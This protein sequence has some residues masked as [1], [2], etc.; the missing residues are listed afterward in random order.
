MGYSG[1]TIVD[2][3]MAF[4]CALSAVRAMV[5]SLKKSLMVDGGGFNTDGPVNVALFFSELLASGESEWSQYEDLVQ[6]AMTASEGMF[7]L[8]KRVEDNL[9]VIITARGRWK[10]SRKE[11]LDRF[12][13]LNQCL[14]DFIAGA[15]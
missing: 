4:D 1:I 8:I 10:M 12:H 3:D 15:E 14:L 6:V 7:R 9:P 11:H 2:S 5:K 13:E